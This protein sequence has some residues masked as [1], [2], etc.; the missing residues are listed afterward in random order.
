[1]APTAAP[2]RIVMPPRDGPPLGDVV[3]TKFAPTDG[4]GIAQ[5][6]TVR[7]VAVPNFAFDQGKYAKLVRPPPTDNWDV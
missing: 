6:V 2:P 7:V 3:N 5:T 4:L 1:M